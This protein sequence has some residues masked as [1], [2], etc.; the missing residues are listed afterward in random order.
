[1]AASDAGGEKLPPIE[2][3]SFS[4]CLLP[5]LA[6]K[7]GCI[8]A[9]FL[10]ISQFFLKKMPPKVGKKKHVNLIYVMQKIELINKLEHT[11]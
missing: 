3:C 9:Y 10:F 11:T 8:C 1:M 2:A 6:I 5:N 4:H 7:S